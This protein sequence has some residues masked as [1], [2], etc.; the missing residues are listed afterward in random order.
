[1]LSFTRAFISA[2]AGLLCAVLRIMTLWQPVSLDGQLMIELM[3]NR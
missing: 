1:M 2:F 3:A